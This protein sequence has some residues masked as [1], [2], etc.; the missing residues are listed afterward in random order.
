MLRSSRKRHVPPQRLST[1]RATLSLLLSFVALSISGPSSEAAQLGTAPPLPGT[2]CSIT[3]IDAKHSKVTAK[4]NSTGRVFFFE[5]PNSALLNSL[6][7]AQGIY[8]NFRTKEVSLDGHTACC[9]ITE[10]GAIP[11]QG[12]TALYYS[13]QT[14]PQQSLSNSSNKNKPAIEKRAD[15][16]NT[17]GTGATAVQP[18]EPTTEVANR[19][20]TAGGPPNPSTPADSPT[21]NPGST[22]LPTSTGS[23]TQPSVSGPSS[24][25]PAPGTLSATLLKGHRQGPPNYGPIVPAPKCL[26]GSEA[27]DLRITEL[28]FNSSRHVIYT[29]TNCGRSSTSLPFVV[30]LYINGARGDTVEH[31][32]LPGQSQQMVTSQLAKDQG[33]DRAVLLAIADPQHIVPESNTANNQMTVD[34]IPPCPDLQVEEIKQHWIDANTR[35]QA[36]VKIGNRGNGPSELSVFARVMEDAVPLGISLPENFEIPPLA[37]GQSFI[38]VCNGKHLVTTTT[39]VDVMVDI[40]KQI[41][42]SSPNNKH[43][44]KTLGPH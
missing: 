12:G 33:C 42:E 24:S 2:C 37:P 7:V 1:L 31:Q 23:A 30:D 28:K 25:S 21:G 38:F 35:Y 3:S 11:P 39:I 16:G 26:G 8:A 44:H 22:G 14:A 5:V 17:F 6:R 13:Q 4:E 32:I 10:I 9:R 20:A 36:Q 18:A 34:L 43:V 40:Y 29:V 27:P 41:V 19:G 15:A